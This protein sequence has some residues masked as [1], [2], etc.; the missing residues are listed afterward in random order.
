MAVVPTV[1]LFAIL[2]APAYSLK[3]YI[4]T[5]SETFADKFEIIMKVWY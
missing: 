1:A 5:D 3:C 2:F 4:G